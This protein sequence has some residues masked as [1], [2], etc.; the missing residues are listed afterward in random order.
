MPRPERPAPNR[1]ACCAGMTAVQPLAGSV[2]IAVARRWAIGYARYSFTEW[3]SGSSAPARA[4]HR[5]VAK[6][7]A[8][9]SWPPATNAIVRTCLVGD[10][11]VAASVA[12]EQARRIGR[13]H[14]QAQPHR[15]G[16]EARLD[17]PRTAVRG[18]SD[19]GEEVTEDAADQQAITRPTPCRDD[20]RDSDVA[21]AVAGETLTVQLKPSSARTTADGSYGPREPLRGAIEP[22]PA[23]R[24]QRVARPLPHIIAQTLW[25]AAVL[26]EITNSR[27]RSSMLNRSPRLRPRPVAARSAQARCP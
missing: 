20:R 23:R 26:F 14:T 11:L 7:Q 9:R 15:F 22:M 16:A 6:P 10:A 8:H 25:W 1:R 17:I 19:V 27:R 4:D 3:Q 13:V 21:E 24:R 5:E 2:P 18:D 12:D